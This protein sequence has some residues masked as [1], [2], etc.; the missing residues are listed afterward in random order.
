MPRKTEHCS[1]Q[2]TLRIPVEVHEEVLKLSQQFGIDVNVFV[3][4]AVYEAVDRYKKSGTMR[5]KV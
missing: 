2:I 1:G 4:Q 3:R 5:L